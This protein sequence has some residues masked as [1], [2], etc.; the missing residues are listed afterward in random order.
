MK[1]LLTLLV[2]HPS[3]WAFA[4]PV[5]AAEVT[6]YYDVIKNPMGEL[7]VRRGFRRVQ[8]SHEWCSAD[9]ATM[10]NKL[11]ANTY[12]TLSEFITDAKLI[13]SNCRQYNDSG[14]NCASRCTPSHTLG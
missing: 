12:N 10:E 9:L 8:V 4:N 7:F 13:F 11:E 3:S 2:D 1:K 6:D 5:N 14:S